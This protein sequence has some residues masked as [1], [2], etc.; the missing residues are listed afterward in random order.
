MR[1]WFFLVAL[2]ACAEPTQEMTL[3]LPQMPAGFDLSCVTAVDV[4]AHTDPDDFL[5]VGLRYDDL[6]ERAQCVEISSQTTFE[7][8]RNQIAGQFSLDLEDLMGVQIRGRIGTCKDDP[9]YH[10]A[11]FYGGAAYTGGDMTIPLTPNISCTAK[12]TY[13]VRPLDIAAMLADPTHACRPMAD[14]IAT[15]PGNVRPSDMDP[16]LAPLIFEAGSTVALVD[17][18]GTASVPSFSNAMSNDTCIAMAHEGQA[19][20]GMSCINKGAP[21]LCGAAGEIEFPAFP[22]VFSSTAVDATMYPDNG[23]VLGSIWETNPNKPV[24]GATVTVP[25]G[26]KVQYLTMRNGQPVLIPGAT[27]TDASGLFIL[28]SPKVISATISAPGHQQRTLTMSGA[29]EY[30]G[31]AL[32]VLPKL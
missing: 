16:E 14:N 9:L 18:T 17:A 11:I 13:K 5:D 2:A 21:T 27:A 22:F 20:D 25:A 32:A 15:F 30:D 8:I 1:S 4:V 3:Q 10:E 12:E 24:A 26:V 31:Y 28:Y 29:W 6:G 7:G 23:M 19:V